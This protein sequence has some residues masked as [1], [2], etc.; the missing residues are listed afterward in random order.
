MMDTNE[1]MKIVQEEGLEMPVLYG[2]GA[3]GPEA[4][5]LERDGSEWKV[6]VASERG[7]AMGSTQRAFD[8]ESDALDHVLDKVRQGTECHRAAKS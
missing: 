6:F 8:D 4:V 5:V 7:G 3:F 1:L 2:S